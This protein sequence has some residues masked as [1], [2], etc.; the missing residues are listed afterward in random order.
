M[1]VSR[2]SDRNAMNSST[3][4]R[5]GSCNYTGWFAKAHRRMS[6]A[7]RTPRVIRIIHAGQAHGRRKKVSLAPISLPSE[8]AE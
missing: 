8:A 2:A 1:S 7:E 3:G 5:V 6:P 4:G